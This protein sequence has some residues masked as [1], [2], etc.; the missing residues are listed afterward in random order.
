MQKP[1]QTKTK[2][3]HKGE[4]AVKSGVQNGLEFPLADG[5]YPEFWC[6]RRH[7]TDFRLLVV[8]ESG[9]CTVGLN[10]VDVY[11]ALIGV[12]FVK[13]SVTWG[14]CRVECP[15]AAF[16]DWGRS[17]VVLEDIIHFSC[18][19]LIQ[20]VFMIIFWNNICKIL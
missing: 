10:E 4:G 8:E 16:L 1:R 9:D 5:V 12:G 3:H 11:V 13:Q 18:Y 15:S 2:T 19:G 20:E 17:V 14:S 6:F 7:I